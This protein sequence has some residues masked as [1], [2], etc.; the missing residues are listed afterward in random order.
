MQRIDK[1]MTESVTGVIL[2]GGRATRMDGEDKGLV[3]LRNRPMIQWVLDRLSPQVSKILISANRN[4][5]QY[6]MFGHPIVAD[7]ATDF[8]GPLAGIAA[9]LAQADTPWLVSVPCDSPLIPLDLVGRL[10]DRVICGGARAGVAHDGQRLQPVFTLVHRDLLTDL[11]SY[12]QG[13]ERK[14]DR[15]LQRH[16]FR[17]VDFSDSEEMFLNINTPVELQAATNWLQQNETDSGG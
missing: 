17:T 16:A 6:A 1:N 11:V 3:L 14:I 8:R 10:H 15:W 5:P 7:T 9:A 12:L 2:A 13:G 4:K